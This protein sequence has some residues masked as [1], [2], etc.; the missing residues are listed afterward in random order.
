VLAAGGALWGIFCLLFFIGAPSDKVGVSLR[1]SLLIFG[2]GYLVTIGYFVRAF[3]SPR[4]GWRRVIWGASV[5]VQGTWFFLIAVHDLTHHA[6]IVPFEYVTIA[7]WG[8]A[9]VLS[10]YA[11]ITDR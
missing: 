10:L 4:V 1:V 6:H 3:T 8:F 11:L 5:L 9:L 7:W 2:P